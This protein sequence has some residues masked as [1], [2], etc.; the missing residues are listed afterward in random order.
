MTTT[1]PVNKVTVNCDGAT[2]IFTYPFY[3]PSG[4]NFTLLQC[5]TATGVIT[6]I[7]TANYSVS[8]IGNASGGTFTYDPGSVPVPT[9]NTLTFIRQTPDTQQTSLINQGGYNASVVEPALDW[10]DFQVQDL[11]ERMN[12]TVHGPAV[13]T[14][15]LQDLPPAIQRAGTVLVFDGNGQPSVSSTGVTVGATGA[16]GATGATG[17][18]GSTGAT[19]ATGAAGAIGT[20]STGPTGPQG[21]QGNAGAF[22]QNSVLLT[23]ASANFTVPAGVFVIGGATVGAAGGGGGVTSAAATAA[24]GDAGVLVSWF[25]YVT[26]GQVIAYTNGTGGTAGANTGGQGGNGG[27]STFGPITA[28]GGTGGV[29]STSGNAAGTTTANTILKINGS[30]LIPTGGVSGTFI[31]ATNFR[32]GV[33]GQGSALG[34]P[35]SSSGW[36]A[37]GAGGS[38]AAGGN[39]TGYGASGGGAGSNTTGAFIGGTG[40]P[41]ATMVFY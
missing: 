6:I 9:G 2:T 24:S 7:P 21:A 1:N 26:P 19:G 38:S 40:S 27:D 15:V 28:K 3:L 34:G 13:D 18:A 29:G 10:I 33:A 41:G 30:A 4:A 32:G 37:G 39:G 5:V 25:M 35:G 23:S 36:G 16:A 22:G 8:G 14:Q 12:R 20:G 17:A 11:A 31:T